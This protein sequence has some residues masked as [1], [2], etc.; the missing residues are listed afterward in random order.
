MKT[1]IHTI[2]S[3]EAML[4]VNAFIIEA[5]KELV[6]V[7]TEMMLPIWLSIYLAGKNTNFAFR[8]VE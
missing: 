6:I 1:H 3:K 7:D 5:E 4:H 8:I 2:T